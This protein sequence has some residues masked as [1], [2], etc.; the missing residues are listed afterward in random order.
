MILTHYALFSFFDGMSR[1]ATPEPVAEVQRF[2]GGPFWSKYGYDEAYDDIREQSLDEDEADEIRGEL[3]VTELRA[4]D[5]AISDAASAI[6]RDE[7]PRIVLDYEKAYQRILQ[8]Q[9][10]L[11]K[12][13]RS[14]FAARRAF[15]AEVRRKIQIAEDDEFAVALLY[16]LDE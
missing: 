7:Q 8:S 13:L 16:L 1:S 11:R 15:R 9:K 14:E 3:D 2:G 10:G 12:E 4:A 6:L 5:D